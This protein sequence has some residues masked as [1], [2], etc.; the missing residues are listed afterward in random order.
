MQPFPAK[1]RPDAFGGVFARRLDLFETCDR[2]AVE[3]NDVV[4]ITYRM[5]VADGF[6]PAD[7]LPQDAA[8]EWT[9]R[10][11]GGGTVENLEYRRYFVADGAVATPDFSVPFYDPVTQTYKTIKVGGTPLKYG[12][13][14]ANGL[15]GQK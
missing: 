6:V 12:I 2:L 9:R 8:F 10:M 11:S 13:I 14:E 5:R 3:T 4:T 7:Y 1:G 15:K